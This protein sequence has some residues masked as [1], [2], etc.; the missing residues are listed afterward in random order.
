MKKA[1]SC[2]FRKNIDW[3]QRTKLE[4]G[5]WT[6][7]KHCPRDSLVAPDEVKSQAL[8]TTVVPY[9]TVRRAT[10]LQGHIDFPKAQVPLCGINRSVT[11]ACA[12][13]SLEAVLGRWLNGSSACTEAGESEFRYPKSTSKQTQKRAPAIAV[14]DERGRQESLEACGPAGLES[15]VMGFLISE[16]EATLRCSE[17]PMCVVNTYAHI[18]VLRIW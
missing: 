14:Q 10:H 17:F 18:Q 5:N 2:I 8:K 3:P 9:N 7:P 13:N 11:S 16:W 6:E 15:K 1:S 12:H 4:Q